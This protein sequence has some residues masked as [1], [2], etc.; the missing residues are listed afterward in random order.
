[1]NLGVLMT[2]HV[3]FEEWKSTGL[4]S[5]ELTLYKKMTGVR[6]VFFHDSP[7]TIRHDGFTFYPIKALDEVEVDLI[8]SNQID[9]AE[10]GLFAAR[11][12]GVP[13]ILRCGYSWASFQQRRP[14]SRFQKFKA[15]RYE[16]KL[17]RNAD[18]CFVASLQDEELFA[19][20]YGVSGDRLHVIPNWVDTDAWQP[21]PRRMDPPVVVSVGR[22][23]A[24]K[25]FPL[26]VQAVSRCKGLRL[27]IYGAGH[28]KDDL[29]ELAR[30]CGVDLEL[31]GVLDHHELADRISGSAVY[32]ITSDYEGLPKAMLEAMAGG[33]PVVATHFRGADDVIEDGVNGYLVDR[34]ADAVA[35]GLQKVVSGDNDAMGRRAR[36]TILERFSVS[37]VAKM[38]E[39]L[40]ASILKRFKAS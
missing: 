20:R 39:N 36:K 21:S 13:F 5:R 11:T 31:P 24:Q 7:E 16:K 2:R 12:R 17:A 27:V 29:T 28:L 35:R 37:S 23:V 33:L 10:R 26:L 15:W 25:N 34:S 18:A 30:E 38:E 19:Q 22:L 14:L 8:K 6:T 4:L 9:G 1:M 40:M 3:G 32:A